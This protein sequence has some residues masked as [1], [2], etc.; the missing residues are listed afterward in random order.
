MKPII[1]K[2]DDV[3]LLLDDKDGLNNYLMNLLSDNDEN[4][5]IAKNFI[6]EH[7]YKIYSKLSKN[8]RFTK[9]RDENDEDDVTI[10]ICKVSNKYT[11]KQVQDE[12]DDE[13]EKIEKIQEKIQEEIL[14]QDEDENSCKK[15][16][17]DRK[18]DNKKK[19][20]EDKLNNDD[21]YNDDELKK[22]EKFEDYNN[23]PQFCYD[24][25]ETEFE[26]LYKAQCKANNKIIEVKK[27]MNHL[28]NRVNMIIFI[29]IVGW[30]LLY[31]LN[32][33][34]IV[35]DCNRCIVQ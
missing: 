20:T 25:D 33:I 17:I 30:G 4:V 31:T 5:I 26:Y 34:K 18:L 1:I 24:Y 7:R 13:D 29:C 6:K 35:I 11:K 12:D 2:P 10:E 15:R 27:S 22:Q 32:P 19:V 3:L 21:D 14:K 28:I 9:F 16:K 8:F 23:I